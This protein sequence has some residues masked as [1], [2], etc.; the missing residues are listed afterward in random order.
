VTIT[1]TDTGIG[2]PPSDRER[3]FESFQQG[4]RGPTRE[5]GTGLGL[6]LSRRIVELLGGQMWLDS[7]VGVGSTFGFT[8]P[9][10]RPRA[11][12]GAAE[13][14]PA[15]GQADA[16]VIDDDRPSLDLLTAYLAGGALRITTA[17]DGPSGLETVRRIRPAVVLLD[18]RLPGM[19]GW[20]VLEALKADATTRDI[21]VVVVSIVD[22]H[23]RA[24]ALGAA[25]YLVKP[26]SR[27]ALLR[28]LE[29]VGVLAGRAEADSGDVVS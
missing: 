3:I 12:D 26:V 23:P 5:E 16:V 28:A 13:P 14:R 21:P 18:I 7:E 19:D 27:D 22:E 9:V 4:G 24:A 6:T 11:A 15:T 25:A 2:V 1:V 20:A 8:L 17:K 29:S 10:K